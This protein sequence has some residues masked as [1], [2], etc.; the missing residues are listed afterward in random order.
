MIVR[1]PMAGNHAGAVSLRAGEPFYVDG[2]R[3]V[4]PYMQRHYAEAAG[5]HFDGVSSVTRPMIELITEE[6]SC[7]TCLAALADEGVDVW[8]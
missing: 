3:Y 2:I 4:P 7:P 6:L 5:Q 1:I 8:N